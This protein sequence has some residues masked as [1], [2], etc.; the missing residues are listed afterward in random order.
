MKEKAITGVCGGFLAA[1]AILALASTVE[2]LSAPT[3]DSAAD[4]QTIHDSVATLSHD[5]H[6]DTALQEGLELALGSA[7]LLVSGT[8]LFSIHS[9]LS[10]R[11]D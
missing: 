3:E 4:I 7:T 11:K 8:V 9:E 10:F 6:R 2:V 5:V 1:G